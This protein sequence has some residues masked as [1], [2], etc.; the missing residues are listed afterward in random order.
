MINRLISLKP[1]HLFL[2]TFYENIIKTWIEK[3][4]RFQTAQVQPQGVAWLNGLIF[5][6]FWPGG[7]AYKNVAHKKA[8]V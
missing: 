4:I 8:F 7:V 3:V 2:C 1:I 5:C 6:Q